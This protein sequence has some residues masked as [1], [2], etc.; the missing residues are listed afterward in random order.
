VLMLL[1][2]L[3]LRAEEIRLLTLEDVDWRTG[4]LT[5]HGKARG[6]EPMPLPWSAHYS[7]R[8]T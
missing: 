4:Q 6:P 1:A 2:R 8:P 3:G 7:M 5:I